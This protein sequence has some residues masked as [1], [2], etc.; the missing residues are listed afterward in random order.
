[1]D[2]LPSMRGINR[3]MTRSSVIREQTRDLALPQWPSAPATALHCTEVWL[4]L[5]CQPAMINFP[6]NEGRA[7]IKLLSARRGNGPKGNPCPCSLQARG[8]WFFSARTLKHEY[9]RLSTRCTALGSRKLFKGTMRLVRLAYSARCEERV[10]KKERELFELQTQARDCTPSVTPGHGRDLT[11]LD[12]TAWFPKL[13]AVVRKVVTFAN[14]SP[15][16]LRPAV[17]VL[18]TKRVPIGKT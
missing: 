7:F 14:P 15:A 12:R 10:Q 4:P 17:A 3:A 13:D 18:F 9:C 5:L 16:R 11:G 6:T 2:F 1:M 8:M